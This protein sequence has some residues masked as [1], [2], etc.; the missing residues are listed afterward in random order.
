MF[1][2]QLSKKTLIVTQ[3]YYKPFYSF[4][5]FI[6]CLLLKNVYFHPFMFPCFISSFV[7]WNIGALQ[8]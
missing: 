8:C 7:N 1:C 6:F 3:K 4:L 5:R 2:I